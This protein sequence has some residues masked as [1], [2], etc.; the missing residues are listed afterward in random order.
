MKLKNLNVILG[1]CLLGSASAFAMES[2][3]LPLTKRP[4]RSLAHSSNNLPSYSLPFSLR[5][6]VFGNGNDGFKAKATAALQELFSKGIRRPDDSWA[7]EA[8]SICNATQTCYYSPLFVG[9]DASIIPVVREAFEFRGL[10]ITAQVS[11]QPATFI[12]LGAYVYFKNSNRIEKCVPPQGREHPSWAKGLAVAEAQAK[13][14]HG[15]QN[16]AMDWLNNNTSC[17]LYEGDISQIK[18]FAD[19]TNQEVC[20]LTQENL[21]T[22]F[23]SRFGLE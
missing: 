22:C 7:K 9:L 4:L 11:T 23:L 13:N 6:T 8:W 17:D 16:L 10:Q 20:P 19:L 15:S 18:F 1:L 21:F 12:L 3:A 2:K 5:I 14:L